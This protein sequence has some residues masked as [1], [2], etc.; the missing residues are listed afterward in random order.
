[1]LSLYSFNLRKSFVVPLVIIQTE[2]VEIIWIKFHCE[3][4]V[5]NEE[6]RLTEAV[7]DRHPGSLNNHHLVVV[8]LRLQIHHEV[9]FVFVLVSVDHY[10][11]RCYLCR[12]NQTTTSPGARILHLHELP[13]LL[14]HWLIEVKT[15]DWAQSIASWLALGPAEHINPARAK[16]AGSTWEPLFIHGRYAH[17]PRV[18]LEREVLTSAEC[19]GR[20]VVASSD[21]DHICQWESSNGM[22]V[23]GLR[24]VATFEGKWLALEIKAVCLSFRFPISPA[25]SHHQ[26]SLNLRRSTAGQ[27]STSCLYSFSLLAPEMEQEDKI[28]LFA[29]FPPWSSY[30]WKNPFLH[31]LQ[32]L[33]ALRAIIASIALFKLRVLSLVLVG[34]HASVSLIYKQTCLGSWGHHLA[35]E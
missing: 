25:S 5:L 19:I 11:S 21:Y 2:P 33:L 24:H 30:H 3:K 18:R 9:R 7:D 12:A 27:K 10:L 6:W 23:S 32:H 35:L 17:G 4:R 22:A 34:R 20:R 8:P 15:L 14:T 29:W 31:R 13:R 16:S 26:K 1:M 28:A